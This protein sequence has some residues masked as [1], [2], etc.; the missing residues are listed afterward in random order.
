VAERKLH[1][2]PKLP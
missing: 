1:L 2:L